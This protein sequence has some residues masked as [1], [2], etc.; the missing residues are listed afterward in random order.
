MQPEWEVPETQDAS[1]FTEG[2]ETEHEDQK[3]RGT[4]KVSVA[5]QTYL[6]W[7][8]WPDQ[9]QCPC[10]SGWKWV[11]DTFETDEQCP[12]S[13]NV[14]P[15]TNPGLREGG[16]DQCVPQSP[17]RKV[18]EGMQSE[19]AD[20][21]AQTHLHWEEPQACPEVARGIQGLTDSC[22]ELQPSNGGR[23]TP[24]DHGQVA[25]ASLRGGVK[26]LW[27]GADRPSKDGL[28]P[29]L[30][31][32]VTLHL[33]NAEGTWQAMALLDTGAEV[34]LIRRGLL[35]AD[36]FRQASRPLRLVTAA[37]RPL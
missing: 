5:T 7:A 2:Q 8:E 20:E 29:H 32:K 27:H 26:I 24:F 33:P 37:N 31:V 10:D 3:K 30:R 13:E 25:A 21:F 15:E 4:K 28:E 34:C 6:T 9:P 11:E 23:G 19:W 1:T 35:P 16:R 18:T 22:V 36:A 17:L 12:E 14:H